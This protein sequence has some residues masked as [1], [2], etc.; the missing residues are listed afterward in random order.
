MLDPNDRVTMVN[1]LASRLL[2][3][4]D[5]AVGQ[6]LAELGIDGRLRDVLTGRESGVEQDAVVISFGRVLVLNRMPVTHDGR[7]LGSVT[8]LRDRTQLAEL[9]SE[10]G[11]FRGT[12]DLLRA[13]THEF[14]NQLHTISGLIQIGDYEEVVSYVDALTEGRAEAAPACVGAQPG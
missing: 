3:L 10:I 4:S 7:Q 9:E 6:S 12:T 2:A 5:D 8:T 1:P 14:M 13:Q 11:A